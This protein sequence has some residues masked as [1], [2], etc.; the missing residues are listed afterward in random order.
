M[1]LCSENEPFETFATW[2]QKAKDTKIHE[3]NAM[4]VATVDASGAPSCRM[5][6]MKAFDERGFVFYT[7]LASRKA[8]EIRENSHVALCFHWKELTRQIRIEGTA[9]LVDDREADE[10]FASRALQSR[11][12]A[13]ASKQSQVLEEPL[14]LEK[15]VLKFGMKFATNPPP[16]P[17]FWSGYRVK[18][19]TFEFWQDRPFRLH[20]R[21]SY[22]RRQDSTGW[23]KCRLYP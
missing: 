2:F 22:L 3:P 18:P 12:G 14:E 19:S 7:N 5:V 17:D 20:E 4:A 8:H 11:I 10:Y 16:R 15:R 6:L 21:V 13:W 23:Q 1:E 9:S